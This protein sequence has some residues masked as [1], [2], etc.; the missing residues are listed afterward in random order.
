MKFR[1]KFGSPG[2]LYKLVLSLSKLG[3]RG[4]CLVQLTPEQISFAVAPEGTDS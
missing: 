1:A 2:Q 4:T 3:G